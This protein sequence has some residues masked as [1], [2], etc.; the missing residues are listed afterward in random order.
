M[1]VESVTE[2]LEGEL[3]HGRFIVLPG[4]KMGVFQVYHSRIV[5]DAEVWAIDL[6]TGETEFLTAGNTPSY[7]ST[8]HLLFATPDGVLM[9]V[10][11][12]PGSAELTG[13][14]VPVAEGLTISPLG[15]ANYS[16]SESGTLIYLSGGAGDARGLEAVWVTRS[17]DAA[18][19]DPGWRFSLTLDFGLR[20]SP[21]GAQLA[22][23][24]VVEGNTDIW[25][26]QL[27]D[28]PLE[29]LTFDDDVETNPGW[30]SD[31]QFV[32]YVGG[33]VGAYDAWRR[34]ADGR[35]EAE[36]LLDDERSLSQLRWS[37]DGEWMVF[38][39]GA[40]EG[41]S[42]EHDIVGFRPGIDSVAI[43][44]IATAQFSELDPA[45]SPDGRWLA[46]TSDV[47][48]RYEVY[49]SPFPNVDSTR[50]SVSTNGGLGPLWAHSG[51]ELFFVDANQRLVAA[52]IET[53]SGFTVLRS[54]TLFALTEYFV[55]RGADFYDIA[56]DDQRF[57][58]LRLS[59]GLG[60]SQDTRFILVTNW[61]EELRERMGSN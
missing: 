54:E 51:R 3:G 13:P 25:I 42:G 59:G 28:G 49:V 1:A 53:T 5:E 16:V 45:L 17:G 38:R 10:P 11:I 18:P 6:D 41:P 39:A 47:T 52:E 29:R 7:A 35:G 34:R 19:V 4:E 15:Y 27:P 20:L 14:A 36:L 21:S 40:M 60:G 30:T 43:P 50:V 55:V 26:K 44:L 46:Y 12:D 58:M 23:T 56:P 31:G 9:A 32:T 2:V 8:G 48:G 33:Q 37:S 22:F 24:H 61:F 57:L